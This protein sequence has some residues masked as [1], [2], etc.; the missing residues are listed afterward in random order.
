MTYFP[1]IGFIL[2]STPPRT[3]IAMGFLHVKRMKELVSIHLCVGMARRHFDFT[4]CLVRFPSECSDNWK[5]KIKNKNVKKGALS[6]KKHWSVLTVRK[7][8]FRFAFQRLPALVFDSSQPPVVYIN[9][10]KIAFKG[11]FASIHT[12]RRHSLTLHLRSPT[13]TRVSESYG[14]PWTCTLLLA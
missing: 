14:M 2:P 4:C 8:L 1:P 11:C 13:L 5:W 3:D 10:R 6:S 9:D 12:R 7:V